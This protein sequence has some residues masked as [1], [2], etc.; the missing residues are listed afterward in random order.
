[1]LA[2]CLEQNASCKVI[3]LFSLRYH[4]HIESVFLLKALT[5]GMAFLNTSEVMTLKKHIYWF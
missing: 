3:E 2:A 1:M 5:V 4:T